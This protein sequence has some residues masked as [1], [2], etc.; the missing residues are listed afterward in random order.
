M[1]KQQLS[2][3][4]ILATVLFLVGCTFSSMLPVPPNQG[5]APTVLKLA[6]TKLSPEPPVTATQLSQT[7]IP[8]AIQPLVTNT[9]A[10]PPPD[11]LTYKPYKIAS[12]LPKDGLPTDTLVVSG[13]LSA[14][15]HFNPKVRLENLTENDSG[16]LS[17]SPDG[18]WFAHCLVSKDS[19]TGQWLTV[20]S[21]DR[22]Q[23]KR[24]PMNLRLI[25]FDSY[26]WLD[27]QRLIFPLISTNHAQPYPMVVINP[28]TGSHTQLSSN[29]PGLQRSPAGTATYMEFD[30]SDVVY[31]PSLNLVVF[32]EVGVNSY[33]VVW[34]RQRGSVV[35]KVEDHE[36]VDHYP[37]WSSDG[38]QLA[39]VV[40][41]QEDPTK[42]IQDDW[43]RVSRAGQVDRLTH[44]ADYF[45]HDEIGAANWSPDGQKLAFWLKTE[46]GACSGQNLAILDVQTHQVIDTCVPGSSFYGEA[47]PPVWSLD[48]RY[49]AV[50]NHENDTTHIIL[51]DIEQGWASYLPGADRS[52]PIGWLVG[53]P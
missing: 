23:Q 46:I 45:N 30:Y 47:V 11:I 44:F 28:F 1:R 43:F 48:S 8:A 51:V 21:Y 10:L 33:Y 40:N 4:I 24:V 13:D 17:T 16:C 18:K 3:P 6:T 35:A 32:P 19:P 31:D 5:L 2:A 26:E 14:L 52:Q 29:Y 15:I 7:A 34:D 22:R 50:Q 37:L 53:T 25:W 9:P 36:G 38:K 27:D 41:E 39:V 49:I 42:S 20:E 12:D